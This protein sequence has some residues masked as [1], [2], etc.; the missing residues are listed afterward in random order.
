MMTNKKPEQSVGSQRARRRHPST[1][2]SEMR[3]RC[4]STARERERGVSRAPM[5]HPLGRAGV[6]RDG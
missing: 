2:G 4:K 3:H 6:A 5:R 1:R